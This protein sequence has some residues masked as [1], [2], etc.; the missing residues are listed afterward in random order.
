MSY[1]DSTVRML[2]AYSEEAEAKSFLSGIFRTPPRNFHSSEKVTIDVRRSEPRVAVPVQSI[3]SGARKRENTRYVNKAYEPPVY[4]LET[5]LSS[6]TALKR[7]PGRN[8]FEDPEFLRQIVDE[9]FMNLRELEG[10]IRRGVELQCAQI[11]QTGEISLDDEDGN[12]IYA[13]DYKPKSS[14][15]VTPTTPWAADGS[16]GDPIKDIDDLADQIRRDGKVEPRRLVFGRSAWHRFAISAAVK[17]YLDNRR[18]NWGD[19]ANGGAP[20]NSDFGVGGTYKGT[21]DIGAYSYELW[22]YT[23]TYIDPETGAHKPYVGDLNV[24]MLPGAGQG[25]FDLT[26][27]E[28]PSFGME[29]GS[30]VLQFIPPRMSNPE[31]GFD[32]TTSA[33]ITP[34]RKHLTLSAGT[35]A[36]A[37][38]TAIDTFGRLTVG[39]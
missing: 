29:E 3:N 7:R 35:R 24:I 28:I 37:I 38:P 23:A 36:L 9:S 39:S 26:F 34:D 30:Q 25:R 19:L 32:F 2:E 16:T 5:T 31:L 13:L 17:A 20:A 6:Y 15:L 1:G 33:W 21:I 14:H 27:G 8:P 22:V 18:M 12:N 4:D 10:E 11:L